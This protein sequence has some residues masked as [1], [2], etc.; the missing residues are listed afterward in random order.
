MEAR[1]DKKR[2]LCQCRVQSSDL[3]IGSLADIP[4]RGTTLCRPCTYTLL[5]QPLRLCFAQLARAPIRNIAASLEEN[6]LDHCST[7]IQSG[8]GR[9]PRTVDCETTDETAYR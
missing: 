7:E 2:G 5:K 9:H 6:T 4:G 1:G 8:Q 3:M